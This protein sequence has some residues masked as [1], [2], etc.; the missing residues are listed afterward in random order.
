MWVEVLVFVLS[1]GSVERVFARVDLERGERV[2][3]MKGC[4][5]VV[6]CE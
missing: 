3:M 2:V 6:E 4:I 1:E 5:F